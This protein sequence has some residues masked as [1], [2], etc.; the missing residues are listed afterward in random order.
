[1]LFNFLFSFLGGQLNFFARDHALLDHF[2]ALMDP[3]L[4]ALGRQ[5]QKLDR[6]GD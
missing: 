6:V 2:L 5:I 4:L 1:M 3:F